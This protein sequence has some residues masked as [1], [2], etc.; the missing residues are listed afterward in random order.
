MNTKPDSKL[1]KDLKNFLRKMPQI[2]L[3]ILFGSA[4]RGRLR[5]DS[6]LDIA[7]AEK[8]PLTIERRMEMIG[9]FSMNF[10]KDIDLIDLRS[11]HGLVL[12]EILTKGTP[13]VIKDRKLYFDLIK[14]NVYYN[15]DF[16]P[17]IRRCLEERNR[18]FIFG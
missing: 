4:A 5:S 2:Q 11:I 8:K 1:I 15:Q 6:D 9:L 14:E 16:L 18:R 10:H 3:A 17:L 12:S 7:I 13:V